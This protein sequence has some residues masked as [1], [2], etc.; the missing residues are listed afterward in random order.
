MQRCI[1]GCFS[2]MYAIECIFLLTVSLW[3][4]NVKEHTT[5]YFWKDLNDFIMEIIQTLD[6][7]HELKRLNSVF[8]STDQ[9][10]SVHSED[11]TSSSISWI[12]SPNQFNFLCNCRQFKNLSFSK[13]IHSSLYN[14]IEFCKYIKRYWQRSHDNSECK[15]F[16]DH[17]NISHNIQ[18]LFHQF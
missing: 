14:R 18:L 4:H 9:N 3:E 2:T 10:D 15:N 17:L 6:C 8:K 12:L 16:K 5:L 13:R 1:N 7:L 11:I